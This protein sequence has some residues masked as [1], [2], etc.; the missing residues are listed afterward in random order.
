MRRGAVFIIFLIKDIFVIL[1]INEKEKLMSLK[2]LANQENHFFQ[3]NLVEAEYHSKSSEISYYIHEAHTT[4]INIFAAL[5]SPC[6]HIYW[7]IDLPFI[8]YS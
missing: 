7:V 8:S 3:I 6:K 5:I 1:K 4:F 2:S